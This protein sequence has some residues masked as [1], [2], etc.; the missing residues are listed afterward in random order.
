M[1]KWDEGDEPVL[2]WV[3]SLPPTF[4]TH[5]ILEFPTSEPEPFGPVEGL[6]TRTATESLRRLH[7]Y[8]LIDGR[9][10]G[11][12]GGEGWTELRVTALGLIYLGEWPDLDLVA[13]ASMIHHLLRAA[14]NEAPEEERAALVRAAGI[15]GRTV[16]GVVRD[17]LT[18]VA[19]SAGK[20]TVE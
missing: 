17:T 2:R 12:F 8:G 19:G 16:N 1:T 5:E 13:T 20:E 18:G 15:V 14:A 10:S 3:F 9:N 6:D 11:W 7:G 4:D